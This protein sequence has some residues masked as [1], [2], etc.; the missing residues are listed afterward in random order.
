MVKYV[1]GNW[2]LNPATLTE[3]TALAHA[4]GAM[5]NDANCHIGCTPSFVHLAAVREILKHSSV[6]VGVQDISAFGATGAFTGDV[7]AVQAVDLGAK[8]AIIGHSERRAYHKEDN[9]LLAKK[10]TQ[11]ISAGLAVVLCVGETKSEYEQGETLGVLDNQ[12]SVLNG[13]T[14]LQ[15]KFVQ[16]KLLI[17]YEPVWAIGTGLTPTIDEVVAAHRHIKANLQHLGVD[18]VCVLYGGSVNDK[19]AAEFAGCDAVN[20]ALV[21]GAS[22]KVQSF[23]TIVEAFAQF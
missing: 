16:D 7:S 19:N 12:L 9:S 13:L 4:I 20:G 23:A 15:D 14:V 10:I 1:I 3:A 5:A 2:K 8:F 11:A 21:G 6:W 17:A 18:D 22:L